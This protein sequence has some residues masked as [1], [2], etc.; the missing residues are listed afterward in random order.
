[1]QRYGNTGGFTSDKLEY[2]IKGGEN[3]ALGK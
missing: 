1:M 3:K 2:W